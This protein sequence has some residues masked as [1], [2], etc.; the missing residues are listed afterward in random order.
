VRVIQ[1]LTFLIINLARVETE[2]QEEG[3]P[4]RWPRRRRIEARRRWSVV[5][6]RSRTRSRERRRDGRVVTSRGVL[7]RQRLRDSLACDG[8]TDDDLEVA[9]PADDGLRQASPR[10]HEGDECSPCLARIG[11]ERRRRCVVT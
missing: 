4:R 9:E 2:I 10:S 8:G 1:A 5:A 3:N 6:W 7:A 11:E